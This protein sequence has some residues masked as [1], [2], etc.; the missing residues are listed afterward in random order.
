[1]RR[2]LTALALALCMGL[3]GRIHAA[4]PTLLYGAGKL[5][6]AINGNSQDLTGLDEIGGASLTLGVGGSITLEGL[7][8]DAYDLTISAGTLTAA[9]TVTLGDASGTAVVDE[10]STANVSLTDAALVVGDLTGDA[11]GTG[12]VDLQWARTAS[13]QVVSGNYSFAAGRHNTVTG[14]WSA[15]LGGWNNCGSYGATM[16]IGS[17]NVLT[18]YGG[19]GIGYANSV[20]SEFGMAIGYR[21]SAELHR[22]LCYSSGTFVTSGDQ[23]TRRFNAA[24]I[25]TDATPTAIKIGN[26]ASGTMAL[27][28]DTSWAVEILVVARRTDADG[29]TAAYKILGAI[30][31]QT[32]AAS[33][34]LVG[35]PSYTVIAEDDADWDVAI[36]A[37]TTNGALVITVTGEADK[38]IRWVAS[39]TI[40]HV[41]G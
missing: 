36:S 30:D 12:S 13:T 11:R 39:V 1:M 7:V 34:A 19:V 22:E 20:S 17:E 23:M 29:E 16:G 40:S 31:R 33:T 38:T 24:G 6:G 9:R 35:T 5:V 41:S 28:N 21:A 8:E 32:N 37:D 25:T 27:P 10:G 2:R 18:G 3:A 14:H 4:S 26:Y 15:A